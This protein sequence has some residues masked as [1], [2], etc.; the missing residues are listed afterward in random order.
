L[1]SGHINVDRFL[2]VQRFPARDRT[3]PILGERTLLGGTAATIARVAARYGVTTGLVSR[4]G[5]GFPPTFW[6][7]LRTAQ[8][9]LSAVET[10]AGEPTPTCYI[11]EDERHDQRTLIQQGPMATAAMARISAQALSTYTWLHLTTG[12]PRWHL[13]LAA[14]ARKQGTRIAADPAQ[15]IDYLWDRGTLRRLLNG[16]EI[17]FGNRHEVQRALRLLGLRR[18]TD[19]LELVPLI[20]RTEGREGATAFSR[21][22]SVEVS[23]TPARHV[24]SLVGS[25]DAFRGGFY[26]GWFAGEDLSHCLT[27]GTRAAA[28][29]IERGSAGFE[30]GRSVGR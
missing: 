11:L 13:A 2:R 9:D 8:I 5:D 7:A 29:W 20:V 27:A 15:E 12:N 3:V 25:G 28:R 6:K 24:V 22:G 19:L 23:A 18:V 14:A 17:L 1:V 30:T 10:V 21:I 26:A 16:A 4:L